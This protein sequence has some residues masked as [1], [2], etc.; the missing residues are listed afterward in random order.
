MDE[1][2][3]ARLKATWG[4]Q[5]PTS[6]ARAPNSSRLRGV[7]AARGWF[8]LERGL[9]VRLG[10]SAGKGAAT[11]PIT[12]PTHFC[13]LAIKRCRRRSL[14]ARDPPL[15]LLTRRPSSTPRAPPLP[16]AA[17]HRPRR[18]SAVS[19]LG[20]RPGPL[21][22]CRAGPLVARRSLPLTPPPRPRATGAPSLSSS[23]RC[24][25]R[26]A[27]ARIVSSRHGAPAAV[28]G[29]GRRFPRTRARSA[30]LLPCQRPA[31][32]AISAARPRWHLTPRRRTPGPWSEQ[33]RLGLVGAGRLSAARGSG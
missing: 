28:V 21:P 26:G 16:I 25:I 30:R 33:D 15:A 9:R 1:G 22:G 18:R 14:S 12:C 17:G 6:T 3:R 19:P 8:C 13:L 24:P 27:R 10:A 4:A 7:A 23:R 32:G 2:S 20:A 31:R 29:D 11:G 5:T